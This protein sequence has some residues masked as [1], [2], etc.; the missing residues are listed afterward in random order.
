MG[1]GVPWI[2]CVTC[3][4]IGRD[5]WSWNLRPGL[6]WIRSSPFSFVPQRAAKEMAA[7]GAA[8]LPEGAEPSGAAGAGA[9]EEDDEH[10]AAAAELLEAAGG[11]GKQ[12]KAKKAPGGKP[13]E[14][15]PAG[16]FDLK[17]NTSVY[18]TGLPSDVTAKEISEVGG[19]CM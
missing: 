10:A 4:E 14:E 9:G 17:V 19:A 7:A 12:K 1:W 18:V 6:S 8:E 11:P 2:W 5:V 16:W 3:L 15:R 13:K